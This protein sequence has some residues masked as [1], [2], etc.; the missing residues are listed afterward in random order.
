MDPLLPSLQPLNMRF[1]AR[2]AAKGGSRFIGRHLHRF[3]KAEGFGSLELDAALAASDDFEE[4]VGAFAPH[5]DIHR[6]QALVDEGVVTHQEYAAA[7]SAMAAYLHDPH[8]LAMMVNIVALGT[9]PANP[10][11]P[12]TGRARHHHHRSEEGEGRAEGG[13]E[14]EGAEA[15]LQPASEYAARWS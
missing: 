6:F 7:E 4:G 5:F 8:A 15:S 2:Q 10:P 1:S 13:D 3:L 9:K 12:P 14:G 11:P